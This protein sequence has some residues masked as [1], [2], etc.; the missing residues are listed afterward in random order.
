MFLI[1]SNAANPW[2]IWVVS[3]HCNGRQAKQQTEI[4]NLNI[5]NYDRR[6][7]IITKMNTHRIRTFCINGSYG[8]FII[9]V[10][11]AIGFGDS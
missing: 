11:A 10:F 4:N 2:F 5:F 6:T 1:N 3:G 7:K 9:M 8:K